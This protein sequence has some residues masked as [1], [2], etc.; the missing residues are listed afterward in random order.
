MDT[1]N[2]RDLMRKIAEGAH[3]CGDPGLQYDTT[4]NR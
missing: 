1:Y 4:I 2:A 3:T